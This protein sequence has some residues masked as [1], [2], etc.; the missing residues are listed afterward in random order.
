MYG[1]VLGVVGHRADIKSPVAGRAAQAAIE[2][3]HGE[4][5]GE[6]VDASGTPCVENA[7]EAVAQEDV[8]SF[9]D[10]AIGDPPAI[11]LDQLWGCCNGAMSFDQCSHFRISYA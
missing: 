1:E 8:H 7:A 10:L 2:G 6:T 11:G 9:A 4:M 3:N 5:L